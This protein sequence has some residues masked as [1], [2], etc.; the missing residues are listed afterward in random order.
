MMAVFV[1][2]SYNDI[3]HF[4]LKSFWHNNF[5]YIHELAWHLLCQ[6]S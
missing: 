3:K 1:V 6:S 4:S 5:M 2:F